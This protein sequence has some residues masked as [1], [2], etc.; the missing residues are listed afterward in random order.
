M[1]DLITGYSP[2]LIALLLFVLIVLLQS[3]L[4]GAAKAQS[5]LVPGCTPEADYDNRVYR[6]NRSHQNAVEIMPAAAI[7]LFACILTGVSVWWVNLLMVLFLVLRVLYA[8]V[9]A[10][11]I[12]K[13]TQG[14][15]TF[16]YVSG[17]ATIVA[18]C[19]MAIW[20]A[21]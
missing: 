3:A 14:A 4:V 2:A 13:A 19:V 16:V 17:W 18:L 5:G 8:L 12:G 15:R 21:L 10:Q 20:A 7:A 1:L 9:Y 6:L 11:N